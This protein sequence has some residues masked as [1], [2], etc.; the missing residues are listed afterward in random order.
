[1]IKCL[2]AN[3]AIAASDMT[4]VIAPTAITTMPASTRAPLPSAEAGRP[5]AVKYIPM[6][7][8]RHT[9]AAARKEESKIMMSLFVDILNNRIKQ[10]PQESRS[11]TF[12]GAGYSA[13][14]VSQVTFFITWG[15]R[16]LSLKSVR[17]D[18]ISS[19][20]SMPSITFPNAA[21]CPS[22]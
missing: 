15:C 14:K 5:M 7:T 9:S 16:G 10:A 21:Y 13:P 4:A 22:R 20:T 3:T 11:Q 18:A 2:I 8:A 19:T 1:M 17:T 6:P 12:L